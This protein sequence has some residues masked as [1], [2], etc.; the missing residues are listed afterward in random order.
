VSPAAPAGSPSAKPKSSGF[1]Q[2]SSLDPE[3]APPSASAP[4]AIARAGQ[5]SAQDGAPPGAPWAKQETPAKVE[6][7]EAKLKMT[8]PMVDG[9]VGASPPDPNLAAADTEA[10]PGAVDAEEV[11][12][13]RE[14]VRK[15]KQEA[16]AQ[17]AKRVEDERRRLEEQKAAEEA[18]RRKQMELEETERRRAAEE[19]EQ[20]RL[21]EAER[22]RAEQEAARAEEERRRLEALEEKKKGAAE[23]R[24]N[25]Y[26]GFKRKG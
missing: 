13:A 4:F 1:D 22:F 6:V 23:L 8:R 3:D 17:E 19:A 20:R 12:A 14:R 10:A 7:P 2:T 21:E 18:E 11:A 15:A 24:K 25:M 26:G 9:P 5:A 16:E